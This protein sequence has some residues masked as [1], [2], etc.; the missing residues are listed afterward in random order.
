MAGEVETVDLPGF[1][2]FIAK[3]VSD[4][5]GATDL[6]GAEYTAEVVLRDYPGTYDSAVR[7]LFYYRLPIRVVSDLFHLSRSTTTAIRN[8]ILAASA[9]GGAASFFTDARR[10]SQ[11][12]IVVCQLLDVLEERLSD[13]TE[14]KKLLLTDLVSLYKELD[15]IRPAA[16]GVDDD[17]GKNITIVEGDQ[18]DEVLN[19]LK[20]EKKSV[21]RIG[22]SEQETATDRDAATGKQPS[23]MF[24]GEPA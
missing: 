21:A 4:R 19:G 22:L 23:G 3:A 5:A 13:P 11:R 2:E 7:A 8:H 6:R 9:N 17:K 24:H 15:A 16:N 20:R 18:F 14:T 1:S 12:D 10:K